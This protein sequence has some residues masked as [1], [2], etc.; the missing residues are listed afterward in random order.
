MHDDPTQPNLDFI[1]V[2]VGG[3]DSSNTA[4]L[5]DIPQMKGLSSY[6]INDVSCIHTDNTILH[7]AVSAE[8]VEWADG[9]VVEDWGGGVERCEVTD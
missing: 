5:F 7:R 2:V 4:H 6:H 3:F 1:I 9:C 8:V